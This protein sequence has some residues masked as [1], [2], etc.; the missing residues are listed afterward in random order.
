MTSRGAVT[1]ALV[2]TSEARPF[3]TVVLSDFDGPRVRRREVLREDP[4]PGWVRC[5]VPRVPTSETI[6]AIAGGRVRGASTTR[7]RSIIVYP[8][9]ES[10]PAIAYIYVE[11]SLTGARVAGGSA[12]FHVARC[13]ALPERVRFVEV[14]QR[15]LRPR[16]SH[17]LRSV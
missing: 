17:C 10:V 16:I 13:S 7:I 8:A 9:R 14:P 5:F 3:A 6:V 11:E 15:D 12:P 4:L 2:L 1:N